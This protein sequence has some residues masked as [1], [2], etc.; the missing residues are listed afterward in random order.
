ME[1]R[2]HDP[3]PGEQ[4]EDDGGLK[5]RQDPAQDDGDAQQGDQSS[6]DEQSEG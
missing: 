5:D 1:E 6:G 3:I 4:E 2:E